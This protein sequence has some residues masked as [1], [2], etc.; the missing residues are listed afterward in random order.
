MASINA[1]KDC[2]GIVIGWQAQVRRKGFPA[3]S[4]TFEKKG[5]L[6]HGPDRSNPK[7]NAVYFLLGVRQNARPSESAWGD[8][9]GK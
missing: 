1:R 7:W 4:K 2:D 8:T 3:Q 5:R 9:F 6:K